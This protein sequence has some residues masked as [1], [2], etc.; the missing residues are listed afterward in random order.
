MNCDGEW[1]GKGRVGGD[2]RGGPALFQIS[3]GR[4]V[5]PERF[6]TKLDARRKRIV[7][8]KQKSLLPFSRFSAAMGKG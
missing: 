7:L 8:Q 2:G 1:G 5:A 6:G 4:M 3:E